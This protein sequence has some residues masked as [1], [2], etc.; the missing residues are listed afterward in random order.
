M[1]DDD[2]PIDVKIDRVLHI[3][4]LPT[5]L[6]S[7]QQ[8]VKQTGGLHD[9][10]HIDANEA[11]LTFRGQKQM[12]TNHPTNKLLIFTSYPGVNKYRAFNALLQGDGS[13]AD[14]LTFNQQQLL[15]CHR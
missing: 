5:R 6:L 1:D 8:L 9:G 4:D 15:H 11:V 10:L 14:S 13:K 12:I 7:P 3:P 2:I